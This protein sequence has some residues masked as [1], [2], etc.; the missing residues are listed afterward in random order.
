MT[1]L[2]QNINIK[3]KFKSISLI[4]K[5][6]MYLTKFIYQT[7]LINVGP[8]AHFDIFTKTF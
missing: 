5:P 1:K 8:Y 4:I 2:S 7:Y 3:H 6:P